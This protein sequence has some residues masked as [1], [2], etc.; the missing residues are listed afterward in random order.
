MS[1]LIREAVLATAQTQERFNTA[2]VLKALGRKVSRQY[3]SRILSEMVKDGTL[4]KGGSTRGAFYAHAK[5]AME[6]PLRVR[7]RIR[8]ISLRED[9]VWDTLK[10]EAPFLRRLRSNVNQI[11][12][13]GFLEMLNNAIDHSGS[14]V[15]EVEVAKIGDAVSF[16]V[17]DFGVGVF[18]KVMKQRGLDSELEAVQDILKGK[19]TTAPTA[20][21][22][23][24]I[25][26]TSK[27]ADVFTLES[28]GYVLRIDNRIDDIFVERGSGKR[29]TRVSFLISG[30]STKQLD[31]V[32]RQYATL[33]AEPAFDKSEV[34]IKLFTR[35]TRYLS[36]SEARRLLVGLDR[37]RSINLDFAGVDTV[38]QAFADEIFRVF[39][40][41]HPKIRVTA[42]NANEIIRFMIDRV[43]KES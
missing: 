32:F 3:V 4:I 42:V 19:T 27:L 40:R 7:K 39:R 16:I 38:G 6:I 26:F 34:R 14:G 31:Q 21:S 18:R 41:N 13:Y 15:V 10:S 2:D 29:G 43:Q 33:P 36:R 23:E 28:F 5:H 20:H 35:E 1:D 17:E 11:F 9:E 25:F 22:G 30:R 8:N 37:F 24:G 12:S